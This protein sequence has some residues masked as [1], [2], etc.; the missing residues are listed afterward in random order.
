MEKN[1]YDFTYTFYETFGMKKK[2]KIVP[3]KKFTFSDFIRNTS[4]GTST[5]IIKRKLANNVKFTNTE[6]CED[7]FFKCKILKKIRYAYCLDQ[8]L[9]MYRV[10]T[11]SLQSNY[12]KNFF[13][14]W[15]INKKYNKFN[16]FQ[17]F[18]SLFFISLN[19]LKK[20]GYKK[21]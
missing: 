11:N 16:F 3:P 12:L 13:W 4:I 21:F 2:L 8:V 17:N 6:I 18:L 9:T 20:Y 1:D 15:K 19:S 7:Y 5:M 10:R 14:I